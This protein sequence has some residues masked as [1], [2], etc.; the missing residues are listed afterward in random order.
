MLL[1][2]ELHVYTDHKNLTYKQFN[3]EH[4]LRWRLILDKNGPE[5]QYIKGETN[6]VAYALSRLGM[7][8]SSPPEKPMSA[9]VDAHY[10]AD[11]YG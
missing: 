11:L 1:G 4:V 10:L 8:P 3:K 2:A 5:L 6:I 9:H 7:Q